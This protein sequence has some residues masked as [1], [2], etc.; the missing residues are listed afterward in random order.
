MG[1]ARDVVGIGIFESGEM[2]FYRV[3]G[4][5]TGDIETYDMTLCEFFNQPYCFHTLRCCEV[6]KGAEDDAY[7]DA[8]LFYPFFYRAVDGGDDLVGCEAFFQVFQRGET[9][10]GIDHVVL[11]ELI[12]DAE[13][14]FSQG[15][16]RL[17]EG[18]GFVCAGDIVCQIRT[19]CRG[20]ELLPVGFFRDLRVELMDDLVTERAVQVEVELDLGP[21]GDVGWRLGLAGEVCRRLWSACEGC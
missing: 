8:C 9:D 11:R 14:D 3:A 13:G 19:D 2:I 16:A 21:G 15:F 18:Y 6:P 1:R 4:F 20:D 5:V 7:L 12:E 17:H 10:L